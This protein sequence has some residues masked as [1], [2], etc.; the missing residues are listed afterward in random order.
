LKATDHDLVIAAPNSEVPVDRALQR[1]RKEIGFF[2]RHLTNLEHGNFDDLSAA[3]ESRVRCALC[4][5][6]T[7]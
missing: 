2:A 7:S 3:R 1:K 5:R 4:P 6:S